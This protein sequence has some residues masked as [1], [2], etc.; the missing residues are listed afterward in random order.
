MTLESTTH[1]TDSNHSFDEMWILT[2]NSV[3][4]SPY[5]FLHQ[6]YPL[7]YQHTVEVCLVVCLP[8]FPDHVVRAKT[9]D[10]KSFPFC[11]GRP[12]FLD[13]CHPERIHFS[14][15]LAS[16]QTSFLFFVTEFCNLLIK[17]LF[18]L[19]IPSIKNII[20][21]S[22]QVGLRLTFFSTRFPPS[23]TSVPSLM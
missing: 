6:L 2:I 18:S 7:W 21:S 3:V 8:L 14:V 20:S 17:I 5:R 15:E 22:R 11:L 13:F 16:R 10:F 4:T 23:L 9:A 12:P 1:T 19:L